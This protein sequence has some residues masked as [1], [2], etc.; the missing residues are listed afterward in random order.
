MCAHP[1]SQSCQSICNPMDC[2]HQAPLFMGFFQARRSPGGGDGNLFQYSCLEKSHGQRSLVATVHGVANSTTWLGDWIC[3]QA[4]THKHTHTHTHK[5]DLH[6]RN[7]VQVW[8]MA[9]KRTE[10]LGNSRNSDGLCELKETKQGTQNLPFTPPYLA[11]ITCRLAHRGS[12]TSDK[13]LPS[14]KV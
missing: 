9:G 13:G 5:T 12:V 14:L 3:A 7:N 1:V 11:I 10:W 4:H 2:S 8:R 6:F